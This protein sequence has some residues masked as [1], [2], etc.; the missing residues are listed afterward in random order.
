MTCLCSQCQS[1]LENQS[2][3]LHNGLMEISHVHNNTLY[4][5]KDCFAQIGLVS[6]PHRWQLVSSA[7]KQQVA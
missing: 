5:C 2:I 7:P 4:E 6:V 1:Q 3:S